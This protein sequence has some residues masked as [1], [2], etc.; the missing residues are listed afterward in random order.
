MRWGWAQTPTENPRTLGGQYL[1]PWPPFLMPMG[2]ICPWP[3]RQPVAGQVPSCPPSLATQW[4]DSQRPVDNV[5]H[6]QQ[7]H[8]VLEGSRDTGTETGREVEG[9]PSRGVPTSPGLSAT[10]ME[11]EGPGARQV[12]RRGARCTAG[13]SPCRERGGCDGRCQ[14]LQEGKMLKGVGTPLL[15]PLVCASREDP[16]P[17]GGTCQGPV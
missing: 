9:G 15:Q 16:G 11:E 12:P 13:C 1:S 14:S 8:A 7:H 5:A 2:Q 6:N 4:L 3:P 10:E 17:L